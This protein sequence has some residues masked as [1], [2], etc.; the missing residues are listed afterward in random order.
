MKWRRQTA[1]VSI[2]DN[3]DP[4]DCQEPSQTKLIQMDGTLME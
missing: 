2:N 1:T 4:L 3:C